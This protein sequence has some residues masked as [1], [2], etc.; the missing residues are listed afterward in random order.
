MA[1]KSD[2]NKRQTQL[3]DRGTGRGL[4]TT[5][6]VVKHSFSSSLSSKSSKA[7]QNKPPS[8]DIHST[9]FGNLHSRHSDRATDSDHPPPFR[10]FN[11]GCVSP[12]P[13]NQLSAHHPMLDRD[14]HGKGPYC[15][16]SKQMTTE[17]MKR[18]LRLVLTS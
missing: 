4:V 6:A 17:I 3:L 2:S 8:N 16:T 11:T 5:R 18:T 12:V 10:N 13:G 7:T 14:R 1:E 15:P 9:S